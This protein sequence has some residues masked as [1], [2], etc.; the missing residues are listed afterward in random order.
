MLNK[1]A[2]GFTLIELMV[3]TGLFAVI[4][5]L[6]AGAYLV[7]ISANREAQSISRGINSVSYAL[8]LMTRN[9]RTGTEYADCAATDSMSFKDVSDTIIEY[10]RV[11]SG[12]TTG[13][14]TQTV[15]PAD[16]TARTTDL[17]DQAVDITRLTF[18]CT[19]ATA[20]DPY[21][22]SVIMVVEGKVLTAKTSKDTT[23]R[24]QTTATMR[25]LDL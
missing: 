22:A 12:P 10:K 24:V 5:T 18:Y 20:G 19:G 15:G 17:T 21:Q 16:G 14:I 13:K 2:K 7:M 8:E 1:T 25:A 6:A 3:A 23:F 9:I 11:P 4:M